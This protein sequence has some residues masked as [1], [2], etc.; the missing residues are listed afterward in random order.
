MGDAVDKGDRAD[1]RGAARASFFAQVYEVVCRV[2]QGKVATY[3]QIARILGQPRSARTV[4]WALRSMPE[5]SEAPWQRVVNSKGTVS[6]RPGSPGA[7]IQQAL[8]EEEG[9]V[10]DQEGRI[11]LTIY[12]W[13]GL[14]LAE[15]DRVLNLSPGT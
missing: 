8:L 3:G 2:P 10:F 9:V 11:D 7:A 13:E 14:D 5:D 1:F 4:G 6:F 15:R 12:G